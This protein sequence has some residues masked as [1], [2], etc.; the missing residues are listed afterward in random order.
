MTQPERGPNTVLAHVLTVGA[1]GDS[2]SN[3]ADPFGPI[4]DPFGPVWTCLDPVWTLEEL[5]GMVDNPLA[6]SVHRRE[7]CDSLILRAEHSHETP[8]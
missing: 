6:H 4:W 5:I 3:I 1:A 7:E 2:E 8:C